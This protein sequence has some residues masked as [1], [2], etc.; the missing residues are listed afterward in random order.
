MIQNIIYVGMVIYMPALALETVTSLSKWAAVW[1]T[2]GVCIFYTALGPVQKIFVTKHWLRDNRAF[3]PEIEFFESKI[4]TQYIFGRDSSRKA[5]QKVSWVK[6]FFSGRKCRLSPSHFIYRKDLKRREDLL[7]G[8][9][10]VW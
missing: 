2:A 6:K 3:G 10:M 7:G 1:L 4:S 8:C 9:G 5:L